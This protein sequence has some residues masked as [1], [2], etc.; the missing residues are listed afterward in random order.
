M[1]EFGWSQLPTALSSESVSRIC[2]Y[3]LRRYASFGLILQHLSVISWL[4][5][6]A[7]S[8]S[9]AHRKHH[10]GCSR[11]SW[12]VLKYRKTRK[13]LGINPSLVEIVAVPVSLCGD[14]SF[15]AFIIPGC[16]CV[17][18][19]ASWALYMSS[20]CWPAWLWVGCVAQTCSRGLN[21][22]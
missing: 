13:I 14:P 3:R 12:R 19:Q 9:R 16:Y 20:G 4:H 15:P 10:V 1:P 8:R 17:A 21:P 11:A 2:N 7:R 18:S 6:H 22:T 5:Y